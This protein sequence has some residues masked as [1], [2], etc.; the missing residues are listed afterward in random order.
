MSVYH[1]PSSLECVLQVGRAIVGRKSLPNAKDCADGDIA[2]DVARAIARVNTDYVLAACIFLFGVDRFFIFLANDH[3]DEARSEKAALH[4]VVGEYIK[5]LHCFALRP[6]SYAADSVAK[7]ESSSHLNVLFVRGTKHLSNASKSDFVT[8][9][10][11]CLGNLNMIL[12]RRLTYHQ[13]L[14]Q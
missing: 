10:F 5:H 9:H 8:N 1:F 4:Y 12:T 13:N 2:S 3:A 11:G 7:V 6:V 14:L